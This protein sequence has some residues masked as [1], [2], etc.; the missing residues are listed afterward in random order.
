MGVINNCLFS[1]GGLLPL[2]FLLFVIPLLFGHGIMWISL[3]FIIPSVA[4]NIYML[5]YLDIK[6]KFLPR[7][8]RVKMVDAFTYKNFIIAIF[9]V[10]FSISFT[11]FSINMK[12]VNDV[13]TLILLESIVFILLYTF[14]LG[15]QS[16]P[17]IISIRLVFYKSYVIET[18]SGSKIYIISK[19][20]IQ[21]NTEIKAYNVVDEIYLF[22]YRTGN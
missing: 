16:L 18:D 13:E 1:I 22:G 15:E 3:V 14:I 8:F 5:R 4:I 21:V 6:K 9:S 11:I 17:L 19:D 20:K 12:L 2:F 7:K 10:V